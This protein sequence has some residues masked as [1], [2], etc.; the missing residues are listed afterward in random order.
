MPDALVGDQFTMGEAEGLESGTVAGQDPE[1]GI[2]D[3]NTLL[4]V[5]SL[6]QMT[7]SGQ[8]LQ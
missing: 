5:H 6:Q 8:G 1:S 4:Q 3:L 7:I 2:G